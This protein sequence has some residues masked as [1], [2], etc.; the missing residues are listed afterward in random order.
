M[1][2]LETA[3]STWRHQY[4]YSSAFKGRDLDE[5]EQHLRDQVDHLVGEGQPPEE[6]FRQAVKELG[7]FHETEAEFRSVAWKKTKDRKEVGMF[8]RSSAA[9]IASYFTVAF[10]SLKKNRT[11]SLINVF[12]LGLAISVSLVAFLFVSSKLTLDTNH[13]NGEDIFLVHHT[14]QEE[15]GEQLWGYVPR[16][17][18]P[19]LKEQSPHILRSVRIHQKSGTVQYGDVALNE[20]V[21]FVDPG[22]FEMFNFPVEFGSEEALTATDQVII[23][24][25]SKRRYFGE[26]EA[27]GQLLTL[28]FDNKEP[29]VVTVTGVAEE[30][31]QNAGLTFS[32]IMSWAALEQLEA[33]YE[34]DWSL[35]AMATFIQLDEASNASRV[36]TDLNGFKDRIN[37]AWTEREATS[38][39]LDN[40][41]N[42]SRNREYVNSSI[43][44]SVPWAP[45]IVLSAISILLL[46]LSCFNYMNITI[47]TSLR[48]LREIGVRKVV[49]GQRHQLIFQ[50]LAENIILS[51][52]SMLVGLWLAWQFVLPAFEVISGT[53]LSFNFFSDGRLWI[54]MGSIVLGTGLIS[55]MYP[56]VFISS[57]KPTVIFQG[58]QQLTRKRPITQLLLVFQF[59]LAFLTVLSGI[60][61]TLNGRYHA[62]QEWGYEAD[63]VLVYH[64]ASEAEYRTVLGA[65]ESLPGVQEISASLDIMGRSAYRHTIR[66][67]GEEV[68][69]VNFGVSKSYLDMMGVKLASG[70]MLND[71]LL[72]SG[73][74]SVVINE[75]LAAELN[76]VD[77]L[78]SFV[79]LDSVSYSIVG[80]LQDF[81]Y[82]D[83]FQ[84][85]MPAVFYTVLP[86]DYQYVSIKVLPAAGTEVAEAIAETFETVFPGS[87]AV[88]HFQDE[89]IQEFVEESTG[90][91]HIFTFVALISLLISCL[92]V[93]ALSSQNVVNR[94]K[95]IGIRKVLGSR[96]A[97]IARHINRRL[98][99][100]LTIASFIC[101]PLGYF[102]L[103]A[104]LSNIYAY[105]MPLN[106]IPFVIT[107]SV[108]IATA[109]LTISTQIRRIERARPADI[110][111]SE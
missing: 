1:F 30:F 81:H 2:N 36:N 58:R 99:I 85:I 61:F 19:A 92:S 102:M 33:N 41:Q 80:V 83:F 45:V 90:L 4:K 96:S 12:G 40:L 78:G 59:S 103:D 47:A 22:F 110:L 31:P 100:L 104:L 73:R 93:Y 79:E 14:T 37:A 69:G 24:A 15:G 10:R 54:F 21:R 48:R 42:L 55:G 88:Y 77:P 76:L 71:S 109:Y 16:P 62:H 3:I 7:A 108:I 84:P 64:V 74:E 29:V 56:A 91:T 25:E 97:S 5:L 27:V 72:Q 82:E 17:L 52:V 95:E 68:D 8:I 50:F 86:A 65:A 28:T 39:V 66:F 20:R 38:L 57:F 34:D 87:K 9:M 51:G 67:E 26:E 18:G 106:A 107:Y 98:F 53:P 63:H 35:S 49:G 105:R 43:A 89:E 70:Y 60:V 46:M 11:S 101:I 23:S 32:M 75:T 6:A 94:M 111:R 13:D 44:N